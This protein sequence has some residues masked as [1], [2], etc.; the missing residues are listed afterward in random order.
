MQQMNIAYELPPETNF[1]GVI[2]CDFIPDTK[3]LQPADKMN[4]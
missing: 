3:C 1:P 2:L 4:P